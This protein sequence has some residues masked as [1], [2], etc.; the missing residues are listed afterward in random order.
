MIVIDIKH[1]T[2]FWLI[3]N[4]ASAVLV[5]QHSGIVSERHTIFLDKVSLALAIS[6]CPIAFPVIANS[7]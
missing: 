7:L 2:A 6:M 5:F 3:T 1:T 4:R